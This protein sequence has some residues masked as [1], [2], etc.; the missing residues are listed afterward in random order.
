MA[1]FLDFDRSPKT[2]VPLMKTL[3]MLFVVSNLMFITTPV[4][5]KYTQSATL[6][7]PRLARLSK[8]IAT[9][10]EAA[11]N[12][13]REEIQKQGTPLIEPIPADETH[14][15]LT[16]LWLAKEPVQNVVVFSGLTNY[17]YTRA[18][19]PDIQMTRFAETHIWFKT[20]KVRRDAR[21]AYQFSVND[22]LI[23]EEDETD[24][25]A[26]RARLRSDP[27]NP[28]YV[29]DAISTTPDADN[30]ESLVELPGAPAQL[31]IRQTGKPAGQLKTYPFRSEILKNERDVTVY[32]PPGY[33]ANARPY[34]LLVVFDGEAYTGAIPT[35]AILDNLIAARKIPSVVAV[36]IKNVPSNQ[37]YLRTLE[38]SC[39]SS[40]T[41][42]LVE[43]LLPWARQRYHVTS[44]SVNTAV[45]GASRGALAAA[46]AALDHPEIFGNVF[47]QSGFFVYKDRNW[48]KRV[49]HEVAP[50]NASQEEKAWEEYGSVINQFVRR[51]KRAIRIYL[52]TG[53]FENT[54]HPSVL[55][56]NRHLRDVLLAKRY[57]IQYEEFAGHH[58]PVNLRGSL[59]TALIF[60][61]AES[62]TEKRR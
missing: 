49:G 18:V 40:F 53:I 29:R 4:S 60:V 8:E 46:C 32:S 55:M 48:F 22:S 56:A 7:S 19:L 37:P 17:A 27:L 20:F 21:F 30:S 59:A 6:Q 42:F 39:N 50:D 47:S 16:F 1:I 38:L 58:S 14:V 36:F 2:E 54:Y 26:R 25:N 57:R 13:F 28:R 9:A 51:P 24:D 43:E 45:G 5:G 23:A 61:F 62:R 44:R 41:R 3:I 11:L 12:N 15:W 10:G 34:P 33:N 35:P 52:E 31:W